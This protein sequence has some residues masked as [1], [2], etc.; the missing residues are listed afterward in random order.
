MDAKNLTPKIS[1]K[2]SEGIGTSS[3]VINKSA[4]DVLDEIKLRDKIDSLSRPNGN[5]IDGVFN[6]CD[7][8]TTC[9]LGALGHIFPC[10]F[11]FG[12]VSYIAI[13][14]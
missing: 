6:F 1:I 14:F 5:Y 11:I 8:Y 12:C 3:K 4:N 2:N 7:S 9:Q 13:A 10:I